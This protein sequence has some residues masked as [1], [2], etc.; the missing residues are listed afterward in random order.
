MA[1]RLLHIITVGSMTFYFLFFNIEEG[2][3]EKE[4]ETMGFKEEN[5]GAVWDQMLKIWE[6]Q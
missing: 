1:P 3:E 5:G 4:R 2:C 6:N